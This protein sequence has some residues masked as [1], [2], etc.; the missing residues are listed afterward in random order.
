MI[1]ALE[2]NILCVAED[3]PRLE[4]EGARGARPGAEAV[5]CPGVEKGCNVVP[6]QGMEVVPGH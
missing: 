3:W 4:G 2:I 5:S 1:R 6:T